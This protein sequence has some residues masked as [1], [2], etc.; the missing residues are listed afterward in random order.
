MRQISGSRLTFDVGLFLNIGHDHIS[1]IEHP[2]FEDY[3]YCKRQLILHSKKMILN[4]DMPYF[5]L[6]VETCQQ[7][8]VDY[9]TF[10]EKS[11]T[12]D[13]QY[14]SKSHRYRRM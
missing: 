13:Y 4:A 3:L 9:L 7:A 5:D 8:K 1:P 12:A 14:T 11:V 10:S 2:T 6:L